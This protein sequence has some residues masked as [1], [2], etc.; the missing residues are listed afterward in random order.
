MNLNIN[1]N[2]YKYFYEVAKYNSYTKAAESLLI[3]Q[4]SLSYSIKV[5]ETQ[6]EKKLFIRDNN[7]IKLTEEGEK[8]FNMIDNIIKQFGDNN[9]ENDVKGTITLGVRSAF[10]AKVLPFYINEF[11]KIHPNLEINFKID[12]SSRLLYLLNNKQIDI[13]IDEE[14]IDNDEVKT[15]LYTNNKTILYT[16]KENAKNYKKTLTLDDLKKEKICLCKTNI[17]SKKIMDKYQELNYELC[18]STPLMLVKIEEDNIFGISPKAIIDKELKSGSIKEVKSELDI[19]TADMY[20][21]Y[22]KRLENSNIRCFIDFFLE[23]YKK[24]SENE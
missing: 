7:K 8:L 18:P 19:P 23:H 3:S 16:S 2:L 4:P 6:L 9:D 22:I 20:I 1:L 24:R 12:T 17:N 13:L 11:N 10:A 15:I 5:L 21:S 14:K